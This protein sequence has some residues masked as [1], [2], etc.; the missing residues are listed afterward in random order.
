MTG[1]AVVSADDRSKRPARQ[2][3]EHGAN[4]NW[5]AADGRAW[6]RVASTQIE[7]VT[8]V[9]RARPFVVGWIVRVHRLFVRRVAVARVVVGALRQCVVVLRVDAVPAALTE[10]QLKAVVPRF[11]VVGELDDAAV[12]RKARKERAERVDRAAERR[13]D[14]RRVD[15]FAPYQIVA[16]RSDIREGDGAVTEHFALH[17]RMEVV[18]VAQVEIVGHAEDVE[19]RRARR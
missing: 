5:S 9:E 2:R 8:D 6:H 1:S 19:R 12:L 11:A 13:A 16:A 14:R 7:V 4:L 17:R 18:V 10:R 15:L 3:S